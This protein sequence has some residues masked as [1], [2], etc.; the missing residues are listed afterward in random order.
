MSQINIKYAIKRG[1][2]YACGDHKSDLTSNIDE[3]FLYETEKDAKFSLL[4]NEDEK[5]IRI[6]LIRGEII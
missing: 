1:N 5:I 6:R 4:P 3:A 2:K